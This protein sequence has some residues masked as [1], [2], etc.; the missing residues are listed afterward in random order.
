MTKVLPA[1]YDDNGKH[2]CGAKT[3]AGGR[4]RRL[5][6]KG[7]NRCSK[8]WGNLQRGIAHHRY[9]TGEHSAHMPPSYRE[10]YERALNDPDLLRLNEQIAAVDARLMALYRQI[11]DGA[12]GKLLTDLRAAWRRHQRAFNTGNIEALNEAVPIVDELI[13]IG[14]NEA[15]AWSEIGTQIDR[16]ARLKELETRRR[17]TMNLM[18]TPEKMDVMVSVFVRAI[19]ENVTNQKELQAIARALEPYT[20]APTSQRTQPEAVIIDADYIDV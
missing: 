3:Q 10:D 18:V 13:R 12:P 14:A 16:L 2:I 9:K 7:R 8:H 5:P 20:S 19:R 11:G 4:C 6:V 15:A 1:Q 17:L